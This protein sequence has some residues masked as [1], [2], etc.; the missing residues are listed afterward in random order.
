MARHDHDHRFAALVLAS[1]LLMLIAPAA[2]LAHSQLDTP[3]PA[4]K[5][6]VTTPVTQVSGTFTESIKQDGSKLLVKDA[7]G[8]TIAQGG[9]DPG[10]DKVMTASPTAPLANGAYTVEWTTISAD[11]G[12]IA[13]GTW[14][15]TVAV[16]AT[17]S[18]TATP[19]ASASAAP[20]VAPAPTPTPTPTSA[21]SP[22]PSGSGTD[23]SGSGSDVI[24]PIV[25]ALIVLGAGAVYLLSR[26][27]RP[28]P[29]A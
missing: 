27:G 7:T 26:R 3:T 16:A 17:P 1:G 24:L 19:A 21:P 29:S 13:R 5:S 10:D 11:D 2:T 6:T 23:T 18:P 12:D 22:S 20:S 25:I 8:A 15:F 28:T 4:D 9:V 14:T